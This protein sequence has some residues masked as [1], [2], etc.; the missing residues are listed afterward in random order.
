MTRRLSDYHLVNRLDRLADEFAEKRE[1]RVMNDLI[2]SAN[3]VEEI[4]DAFRQWDS[5][6]E[7]QSQGAIERA[8]R[9]LRLAL[10][11]VEIGP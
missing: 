3:K 7:V 6:I 4:I 10:D 2:D 11:A 1:T 8:R 5:A 9:R